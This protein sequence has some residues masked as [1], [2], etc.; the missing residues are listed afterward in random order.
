[1]VTCVAQ[2]S[3]SL[4]PISDMDYPR[5]LFRAMTYDSSMPVAT[6]RKRLLS[7]EN[8]CHNI[9]TKFSNDDIHLNKKTKLGKY[10]YTHKS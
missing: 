9:L 3:S 4:L 1:M 7:D 8:E 10:T 6:Y 2:Q 5:K